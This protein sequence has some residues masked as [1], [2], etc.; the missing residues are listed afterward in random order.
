MITL[1]PHEIQLWTTELTL[2]EAALAE[3]FSLLNDEERERAN[4][5][6][7]AIHRERFIAGRSYLREVLG[8]Y[9]D[10]DPAAVSIAYDQ[11]EK[12]YLANHPSI[13]FNVSHSE[14]LAVIAVTLNYAIGVDL[15][16]QQ[17]EFNEALAKRFFSPTEYQILMSLPADQQAPAFYRLWARKEAIVKAVGEGL[18]LSLASFTVSPFDIAETITL[19][20]HQQ[21]TLLPLAIHEA[22]PAAVA[23]NQSVTQL[24]KWE[25]IDHTGVRLA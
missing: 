13:Q 2:T 20:N 15:E 6:H 9:L 10:C 4:R 23:T 17:T 25:L 21:W 16:K 18:G 22:F 5:Y 7:F 11:F 19:A 1:T 3:K 24:T 8:A 12:P 14:H